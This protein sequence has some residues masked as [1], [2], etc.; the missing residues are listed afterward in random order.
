MISLKIPVFPGLN[1]FIWSGPQNL[2]P[3]RKFLVR[4]TF[5][6]CKPL[7]WNVPEKSGLNHGFWFKPECAVWT[8][9]SGL[10]QL[11]I[12]L[13]RRSG[14]GY[15]RRY[16]R[17]VLYCEP[18]TARFDPKTLRHRILRGRLSA[19]WPLYE[20]REFRPIGVQ[21][22]M[23][24]RRGWVRYDFGNLNDFAR[25][26]VSLTHVVRVGRCRSTGCSSGAGSPRPQN[27]SRALRQSPC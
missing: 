27:S 2:G 15:S 17:P 26:V 14:S 10:N 4:T 24:C 21:S 20:P 8:R 16:T 5:F 9:N 22:N 1:H 13:K 7:A 6:W 23:F 12:R 19:E 25:V 3:D 11:P 18:R